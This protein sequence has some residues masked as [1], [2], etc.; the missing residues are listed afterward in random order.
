MSDTPRTD[1]F[2]KA[3]QGYYAARA[4][5]DA[6]DELRL[7]ERENQALREAIES[8][9]LDLSMPGEHSAASTLR[10]A[11]KQNSPVA[12]AVGSSSPLGNG[13]GQL[14]RRTT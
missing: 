7:I 9:L 13:K 12:T 1:A 2:V 10:A 5:A 14:K 11:L 6:T 3:H 8:A 4:L